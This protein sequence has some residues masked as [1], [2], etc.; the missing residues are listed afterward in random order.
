MKHNKKR[1]TG[2]IYE[3]LARSLT[4]AIVDKDSSSQKK[5]VQLFKEHFSK[6]GVL[7]NEME[8]YSALLDTTHI[9]R[10]VAE[11]LLEETKKAHQVLGEKQIF[12]AQSQLIAAVNKVMGQE[13]W[14][15][16]VPN[17][18]SLASVNAI[19][20]SKTSVKKRVLFEQSIVDKMSAEARSS[21]GGSMKPIDN[22]AYHSFIKKFN[23]KYGSL[24][25][26]QKDLLNRYITS[27]A[28]DGFELRVYLNEELARIKE[29]LR[30]HAE[31]ELDSLISQK[32][33][34][35]VKFLEEFRKREFGEQ[36]LKK[37][38]KSQEL[39]RELAANDHN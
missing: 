18:K 17:F 14:S 16:F 28:D 30:T 25:Q 19:F 35:V 34:E 15:T 1:N 6:G 36:D 33:V 21:V 38:L 13:A 31:G 4:K 7:A 8:L 26:E 23:D 27:F 32:A 39:V 37:I 29:I 12:R 20:G 10:K 3:V 11:R 5:I 2:F 24:L 22:L 9:Q